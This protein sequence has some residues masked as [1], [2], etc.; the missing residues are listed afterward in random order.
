M[1]AAV[2]ITKCRIFFLQKTWRILGLMYFFHMSQ[3]FCRNSSSLK[4]YALQKTNG[5]TSFKFGFFC[6]LVTCD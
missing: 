2:I 6:P 4:N 3:L 1:E 5:E